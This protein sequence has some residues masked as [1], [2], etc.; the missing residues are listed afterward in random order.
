MSASLAASEYIP[1]GK[2][3]SRLPYLYLIPLG[4]GNSF[5]NN[6]LIV[7]LDTTN[8]GMLSIKIVFIEGEAILIYMVCEEIDNE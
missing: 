7:G 3:P 4:P 8:A 6:N 5:I 2:P 1:I